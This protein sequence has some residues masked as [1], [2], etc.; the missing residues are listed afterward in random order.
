MHIR[1]HRLESERDI[2]DVSDILECIGLCLS[3]PMDRSVVSSDL[4]RQ[5]Q[6]DT[7]QKLQ[8]RL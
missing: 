1:K 7:A 3:D 4:P 2:P 6:I 5:L 8:I